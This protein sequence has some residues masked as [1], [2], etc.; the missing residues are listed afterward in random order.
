M[1]SSSDELCLLSATE[2]AGLIRARQISERELMDAHVARIER[3]DP[4]INA[5]VTRA[6][7]EENCPDL[8][9]AEEVFRTLRAWLF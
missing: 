6:C 8:T 4:V 1:L 2:Q 5:V 3:L 9:D 7:V